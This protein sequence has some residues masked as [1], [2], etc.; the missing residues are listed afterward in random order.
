MRCDA[1]LSW[2]Q[3]GAVERISGS[4]RKS[5]CGFFALSLYLRRSS[6]VTRR[7]QPESDLRSPAPTFPLSRS[8]QR[9]PPR[10]RLENL[11]LDCFPTSS[12]PHRISRSSTVEPTETLVHSTNSVV[13]GSPHFR[14][15]FPV[16]DEN[17]RSTGHDGG[18]VDEGLL[19]TYGVGEKGFGA[20]F[21]SP[22]TFAFSRSN[23]EAIP[24]HG[25][26]Y[27]A[28]S[29]LHLVE[30]SRAKRTFS[31]TFATQLSST[32]FATRAISSAHTRRITVKLR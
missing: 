30:G 21:E 15:R 5:I 25:D 32:I 18:A 31:S 27:C 19:S 3:S 8:G 24:F 1:M 22:E 4:R 9:S 20:V 28:T 11:L 17:A 6:L 2:S 13:I 16:S 26:D 14:L 12:T 29:T 7:S 10:I 23:R